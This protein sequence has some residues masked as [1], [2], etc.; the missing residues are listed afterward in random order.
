MELTEIH[1]KNKKQK[2]I[3]AHQRNKF[4]D[5]IYYKKC[6]GRKIKEVLKLFYA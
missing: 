4:L 2:T 5:E 1:N 3:A 6:Q